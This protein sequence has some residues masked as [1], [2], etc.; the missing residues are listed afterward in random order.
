MSSQVEPQTPYASEN[1]QNLAMDTQI[2]KRN[3]LLTKAHSKIGSLVSRVSYLSPQ[4]RKKRVYR[5]DKSQK[6][7]PRGPLT[8]HIGIASM[9]CYQ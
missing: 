5:R 4:K 2:P 7:S 6:I 8:Q 1:L 3:I 9:H